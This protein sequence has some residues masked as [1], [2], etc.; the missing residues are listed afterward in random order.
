MYVGLAAAEP[1]LFLAVVILGEAEPHGVSGLDP[2][3]PERIV[4]LGA[5]R[6]QR[7]FTAAPVIRAPF[8]AFHPPEIGQHIRIGPAG[9]AVRCPAIVIAAMPPHIS[10][11]IDRR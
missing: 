8:P 3:L 1:F 7:A 11:H 5:L 4:G 2:G 10:H 9:G 6:V